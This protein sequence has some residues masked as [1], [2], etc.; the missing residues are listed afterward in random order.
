MSV[1][2]DDG[3]GTAGRRASATTRPGRNRLRH[4]AMTRRSPARA[5]RAVPKASYHTQNALKSAL[6]RHRVR[7]PD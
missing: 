2:S 3:H 1:G 7:Y 4:T 5:S 6:P